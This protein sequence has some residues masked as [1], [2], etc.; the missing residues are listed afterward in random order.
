MTLETSLWSWLKRWVHWKSLHIHV[1]L[2]KKGLSRC[3]G[4]ASEKRIH[5]K[6][7]KPNLCPY[8][9]AR[10]FACFALLCFFFTVTPSTDGQ[11]PYISLEKFTNGAARLPAA[12]G[13]AQTKGHFSDTGPA[14]EG[15][16]FGIHIQMVSWTYSSIYSGWAQL[17]TYLAYTLLIAKD[18]L[19]QGTYTSLVLLHLIYVQPSTP[20]GGRWWEDA[21]GGIVGQ[22]CLLWAG[23]QPW[24][25]LP[26]SGEAAVCPHSTLTCTA[27]KCT[28][29][30]GQNRAQ[31]CSVG[32]SPYQ[33]NVNF[34]NAMHSLCLRK[35]NCYVK[36]IFIV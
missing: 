17:P 12:P 21:M 10:R 2:T 22:N 13:V 11:Q 5:S 28:P 3:W 20:P 34:Q 31:I 4:K 9:S 24:I 32:R 16:S 14:P 33:D 7:K 36:S 15:L 19:V 23:A 6:N 35:L 26:R 1:L 18:L 30:A 29:S 25:S 8:Q 27:M